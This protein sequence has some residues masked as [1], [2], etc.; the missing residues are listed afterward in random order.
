MKKLYLFILLFSVQILSAQYCI[1]TF[2]T[3]CTSNDDIGS[4]IIEDSSGNLILNHLNTGC[5]PGGYGDFTNDPSLH[6]ELDADDTYTITITT[7]YSSASEN[8]RV[9]IDFDGN[10]SFEDPGELVFSS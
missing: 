10:E 4:V 7:S 1:P 3:G 8:Q 6:I 5:S 9:W 2:T